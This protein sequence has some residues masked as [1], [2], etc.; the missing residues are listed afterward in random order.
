MNPVVTRFPPSPTGYLHIGRARTA[1]FNFLYARQRM[2]TMV[3]R[4]ED[5]DKERSKKEYEEN[6]ID[7][8]KWLGIDYD[9]GPFRQSERTE[10][11]IRYLKKLIDSGL[12]YVSKETPTE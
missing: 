8:L 4:I 3:F 5:T 1:L 6:I 9:Q 10:I 12:A 2:G 11:Y 7:V